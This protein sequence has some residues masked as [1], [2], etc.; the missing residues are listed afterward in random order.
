MNIKDWLQNSPLP[1]LEARML[2]QKATSFTR[3]QLISHDTDD[4][5]PTQEQALNHWQ[6]ER[7]NGKPMAYIM[8][9]REFFGRVFNVSESVL[10]P[11]PET[12]HLIEAVLERL[13]TRTPNKIWDLGT[14]SG[15]I[16]I[17]LKLERP[18][19]DVFASDLSEDALKVAQANA[20][21]LNAKIH[22]A[23]GS[24][25]DCHHKTQ[26][27]NSFDFIVSNPPYI[28]QEDKHLAQG[29]VRFEPK[30]ALTD[31]DD[32]LSAYKILFEQGLL[33]LKKDGYLVVEHGYDQKIALHDLLQQYN[34]KNQITLKDLAGQDRITLA[35]A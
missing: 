12:E 19:T 31:F 3:A 22:F 7:L 13:P 15:I 32:G 9:E 4:L 6:E 23:Q 14:G 8:G 1:K 34:Y 17:T 27:K 20:Q 29:D 28:H 21:N 11:R 30:M 16:A 5:T 18:E 26:E 24:W 10:I 2:L 33:W 35:Q 25:F